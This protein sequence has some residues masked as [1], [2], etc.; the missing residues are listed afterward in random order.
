MQ[1]EKCKVRQGKQKRVLGE[2]TESQVDVQGSDG[3]MGVRGI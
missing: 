2:W 3:R 1:N